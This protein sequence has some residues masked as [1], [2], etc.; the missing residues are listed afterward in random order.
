M[1]KIIVI[2]AILLVIFGGGYLVVKKLQS[3]FGVGGERKTENGLTFVELKKAP[4]GIE[5][6]FKVGDSCEKPGHQAIKFSIAGLKA[7]K[8]K[9]FEYAFS[10]VD[11]SKGSLQ[12]NGSTTPIEVKTDEYQ[13]M[14]PSC[15]EL[16]LFSCSAGGKCVFYKVSSIEGKYTFYF[17]NGEVG[18]WK[19]TYRVD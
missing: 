17:E 4:G 16:G 15:N 8:V 6:N 7:A 13:P 18:V 14:T 2:G 12:G 10:Y 11:E 3:I 5:I 19:E 1:K 9:Q